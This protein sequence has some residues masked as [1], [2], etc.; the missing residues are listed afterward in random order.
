VNNNSSNNGPYKHFKRPEQGR[1]QQTK[2]NKAHHFIKWVIGLVIVV[3]VA[4]PVYLMVNHKSS[5]SQVVTPAKVK[6]SALSS[7]SSKSKKIKMV[8]QSSKSSSS[9]SASS[10]ESKASSSSQVAATS[11]VASSSSSE[12]RTYVIQ[13]G[14]SLSSIAAA[15]GMSVDTLA[16]LN[17]I[18]DATSIRAGETLRL[19]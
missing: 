14:D 3:L 8:K 13:E 11:S 4:V 19:N 7:T 17:N 18:T 10:V 1:V 16:S 5:S 2:P 12:V 6:T 15:H 9:S